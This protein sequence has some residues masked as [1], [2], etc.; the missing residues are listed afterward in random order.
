MNARQF[1]IMLSEKNHFSYDMGDCDTPIKKQDLDWLE[2]NLKIFAEAW[3]QRIL[4]EQDTISK[5][6]KD[7]QSTVSV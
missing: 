2:A 6:A 5:A 7:Y 4:S 3:H 1:A